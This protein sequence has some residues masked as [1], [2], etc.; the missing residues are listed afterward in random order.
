MGLG[1]NSRDNT[2]SMVELSLDVFEMQWMQHCSGN[3]LVGVSWSQLQ[4][5]DCSSTIA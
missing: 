2:A 1:S 3:F 4:S 5:R